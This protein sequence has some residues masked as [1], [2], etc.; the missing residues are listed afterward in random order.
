MSLVAI[1]LGAVDLAVGNI[2]GSSLFNILILAISDVAYPRGILLQDASDLHLVSIL[3]TIAV[4]AIAIIGLVHKAQAKRFLLAWDAALI[5]A[6]Y[7]ANL[8]LLATLRV[9]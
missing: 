5:L 9:P 1:R 3:S 4:S 7:A 2:L 6:V 8:V